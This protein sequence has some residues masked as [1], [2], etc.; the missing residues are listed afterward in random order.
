M[1]NQHAV[2]LG[3]LGGIKNKGRKKSF[4]HRVKLSTVLARARQSRKVHITKGL[5]S[6]KEILYNSTPHQ[7]SLTP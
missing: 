3:R 5:V 1:K 7:D 6:G 2:E 4:G